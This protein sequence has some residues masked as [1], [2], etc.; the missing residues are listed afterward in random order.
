MVS[1]KTIST[2]QFLAAGLLVV[3]VFDF[4]SSLPLLA[5]CAFCVAKCGQCDEKKFSLVARSGSVSFCEV[6]CHL[7]ESHQRKAGLF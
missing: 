2:H 7:S 5:V 3:T 4:S 6:S 1:Q